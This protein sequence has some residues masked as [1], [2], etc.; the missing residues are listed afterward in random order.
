MAG[1][2]GYMEKG[3]YSH[4]Q[5]GGYVSL[6][7]FIIY[8]ESGR[9]C[10]LLR[11]SND[12]SETVVAFGFVLIQ[13]DA[14]GKVIAKKKIEYRG[15]AI[16]PDGV[17]SSTSGIILDSR[18]ADF[19]VKLTY[20]VC[21]LYKYT[22]RHGYPCRHYD[23]RGYLPAKKRKKARAGVVTEIKTRNASRVRF[24]GGMVFLAILSVIGVFLFLLLG[25][26]EFIKELL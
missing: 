13:K 17:Y 15:L 25:G 2:N 5:I 26:E 16:V 6:K 8:N 22:F 14:E 7:Q 20:M 10:L 1:N 4:P 18:C 9:R 21:G 12:Y 23:P 3:Y 11:F 24:C 19:V